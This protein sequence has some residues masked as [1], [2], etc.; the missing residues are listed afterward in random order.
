M[1]AHTIYIGYEANDSYINDFWAYL[2]SI[3]NKQREK[4][5]LFVTGADRPPLLGFK[6]MSPQ[7]MIARDNVADGD[8]KNRFPTAATCMNML[9]LPKYHSKEDLKRTMDYVIN[10]NQGFQLG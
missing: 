4:F 1:R 2:E 7:M 8:P 6:M 3:P 9:R 10:S 5:L